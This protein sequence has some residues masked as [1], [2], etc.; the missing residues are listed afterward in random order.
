[1]PVAPRS[2]H[3]VDR[4]RKDLRGERTTGLRPESFGFGSR[5]CRAFSRSVRMSAPIFAQLEPRRPYPRSPLVRGGDSMT[6]L[7]QP[8]WRAW[9]TIAVVIAIAAAVALIVVY[10]GGGSGGGGGG[11]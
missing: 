3:A 6:A 10:S 7:F 4:D 1:M 5:H 8:R 2:E 9:L 11:Y